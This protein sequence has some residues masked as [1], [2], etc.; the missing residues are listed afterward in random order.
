MSIII[1]Y[2]Q[3]QGVVQQAHESG[4]SGAF[5]LNLNIRNSFSPP[6]KSPKTL[7]LTLKVSTDHQ[8]SNLIVRVQTKDKLK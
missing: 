8:Y 7:C 3:K 4:K 5:L 6:S 2:V 1:L